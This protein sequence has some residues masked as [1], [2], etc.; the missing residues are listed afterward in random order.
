MAIQYLGNYPSLSIV[1]SRYPN[2]GSEGDLV[3]INDKP[4][5]WN[6]TTNSWELI[7]SKDAAYERAVVSCDLHVKKDLYVDGT[8]RVKNLKQPN[9]GLFANV[10]ALND[11]NPTPSVGDW[12]LVGTEN[13]TIYVCQS[14]GVWQSSGEQYNGGEITLDNY[15]SVSELELATQELSNKNDETNNLVSELD[16]NAIR[17]Q[18]D[19][20]NEFPVAGNR[21][22]VV[23]FLEFNTMQ[24]FED[25]VL[26]IVT[27]PINNNNPQEADVG[28]PEQT[29]PNE[30]GTAVIG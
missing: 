16:L 19:S 1:L 27:Q 3:S 25:N 5:Q 29:E 21:M 22:V 12:A 6:A 28:T 23:D 24:R 8:L 15:V 30:P 17:M 14:E 18:D 11:K 20:D 26:Y 10:E 9:C 13:P 7:P 2:G 4:Y